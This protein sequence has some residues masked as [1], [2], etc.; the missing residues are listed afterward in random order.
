MTARRLAQLEEQLEAEEA[1]VRR[2][3]QYVTLAKD[4]RLQEAFVQNRDRHAALC[5]N[6]RRE[7]RG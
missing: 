7:L 6:L 1:A 2:F 4:P 5:A 3:S